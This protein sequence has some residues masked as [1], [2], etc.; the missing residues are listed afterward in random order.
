MNKM[1][2]ALRP[3]AWLLAMA[4]CLAGRA[5]ANNTSSY[6]NIDVTVTASLSVA[7]DGVNSSSYS[8]LGWSGTPN[9]ALVSQS[10]ATVRND[11]GILTEKWE[12]FTNAQSIDQTG[13]NPWTNTGSTTSVGADQ[14]AVQAVFGSSHTTTCPVAAAGDW[15]GSVAAT[16][17]PSG[18]AGAPQYTNPG[19]QLSDS[20]LTTNGSALP[21]TATNSGSMLAGSQRA[22]CWRVITP[23]STSSAHTQNIQVI[24]EAF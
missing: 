23:Q 1:K 17:L 22:L 7:V 6:L 9:T 5:Q 16:P 21:D 11:S 20:T 4:A 14:F 13:G 8:A 15:N 2:K 3:G 18:S 24:V 10:T 12:L 19:G